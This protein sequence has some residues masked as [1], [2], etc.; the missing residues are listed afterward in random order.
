MRA[1]DIYDRQLPLHW[2][3][4]QLAQMPMDQMHLQ[5]FEMKNENPVI[6]VQ[7]VVSIQEN[8]LYETTLISCTATLYLIGTDAPKLK[9]LLNTGGSSYHPVPLTFS[10]KKHQHLLTKTSQVHPIFKCIQRLFSTPYTA[11]LMFSLV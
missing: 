5:D 11:T 6:C 9:E 10:P 4:R 3:S 7:R 1:I 2:R 8:H